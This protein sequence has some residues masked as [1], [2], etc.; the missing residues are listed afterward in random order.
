MAS[1][2]GSN[3]R[4]SATPVTVLA[5]L[6][7]IAITTLVLVWAIHFHG[8][9]AFKSNNK[10]KIFNIHPVLMV[11][12]FILVGG[13]AI[14]AYKTIPSKKKEPKLVHLILN[15][16]ALL[17]GIIGIYAVFK[18]HNELGIPDMYTLHSWFGMITICLYG[19][20]WLLGFFSFF[21]PGATMSSR[22]RL[23]PWHWFLG[24]VIFVMAISTAEMGLV[25]KF[26]FLGLQ[27]GQEALIINFTGLLLLLFAVSV[28][29]SVVLPR[30]S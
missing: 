20:Q 10:Q 6:L 27:H 9:L 15:L 3:F 19:L 26:T 11:I 8:G 25:E 22:G 18:Y 1:R 23:V 12:G 30:S 16:I 5:H 28:S 13:E 17:V 2:D 14:M 24:M 4:L 29:L 21:F 7:A